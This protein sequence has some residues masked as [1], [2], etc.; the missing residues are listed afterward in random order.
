[1]SVCTEGGAAVVWRWG[2]RRGGGGERRARSGVDLVFRTLDRCLRRS[3]S[4]RRRTHNTPRGACV[5]EERAVDLGARAPKWPSCAAGAH[6]VRTLSS[7]LSPTGD[8]DRERL[9]LRDLERAMLERGRGWVAVSEKQKPPLC[10]ATAAAET[11]ERD[12]RILRLRTGAVRCET[13]RP[14]PHRPAKTENGGAACHWYEARRQ[15]SVDYFF[16]FVVLR[17]GVL[18]V[19]AHSCRRIHQ[20]LNTDHH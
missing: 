15:Y 1:M 10:V 9:M 18:A 7:I 5:G 14:R 3:I 2:K 11:W 6:G 4:W 17:G 19:F 13:T 12:R 8:G 20:K 16:C